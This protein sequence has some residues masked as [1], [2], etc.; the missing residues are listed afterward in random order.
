MQGPPG[1]FDFLLIVLAEIRND[2]TELQ[3][4]V[5][6]H[7]THP[8]AEES[9]THSSAEE[10]PLPQEFSSSLETLDVGSGDDSPGRIETRDLGAPRDFYP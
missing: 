3:E 6:G 9:R 1:S 8:S 7:R 4:K 10:F 5:F 2:I